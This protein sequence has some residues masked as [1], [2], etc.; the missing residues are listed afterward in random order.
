MPADL[1]SGI[2][3]ILRGRADSDR[4]VTFNDLARQFGASAPVVSSL[5]RQLVAKGLAQPSYVQIRGVETMY[6]LLPLPVA[7][8][9]R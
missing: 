3:T 1:E 9:S 2:L 6:A 4:P 8:D 7:V 5:G